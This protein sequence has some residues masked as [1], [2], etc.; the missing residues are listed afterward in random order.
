MHTPS[1]TCIL[2]T[3]PLDPEKHLQIFCEAVR[4]RFVDA[5][6]VVAEKKRERDLLL[7]A[8][9]MNTIYVPRGYGKRER[10]SF[11]S[12][13]G[14]ATKTGT[15][16]E[17][18]IKKLSEQNQKSPKLPNPLNTNPKNQKQTQKP[19]Q[20]QRLKF[21]AREILSRYADFTWMSD[22]QIE[23]VALCKMGAKKKKKG[24]GD[25]DGDEEYEVEAE[26][27][28]PWG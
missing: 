7:H 21:D 1:S 20:H 14:N 13:T 25:E 18:D 15:G 6:F 23:K 2:Y 28:I 22:V 11:G 9:I 26:V 10:D 24:D 12:R 3:S 4:E 5:G 16:D 17:K 8:T 27:E 19:H